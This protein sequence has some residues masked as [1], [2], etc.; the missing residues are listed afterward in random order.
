MRTS[1]A[2]RVC[3]EGGSG[4]FG[5]LSQSFELTPAQAAAGSLS[6][7]QLILSGQATT[8]NVELYDLG[9]YPASGY[10]AT[11]ATYTPGSLTDLLHAGDSFTY[12]GAA[13]GVA[14]VVQ[15]SFSGADAN[16]TFAPNE[17]Y[18]FQIDPTTGTSVQWARGSL[19]GV[20]EMYRMNQ[21]SSGNMGALNGSTRDASFALTAEPAPE[22]SA[23]AVLGMGLVGLATMVRRKK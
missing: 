17:L 15:L 6:T 8:F 3:N 22:P 7:I 23:F 12:S 2:F 10:P 21:F 9:P 19:G 13:G 1:N 11:S 14:N 20:G 16:I 18:V 5:A 4:G